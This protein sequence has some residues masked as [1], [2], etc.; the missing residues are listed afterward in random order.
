MKT[1]EEVDDGSLNILKAEG[2]N[3]NCL[4]NLKAIYGRRIRFSLCNIIDH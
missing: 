2:S 4:K 3:V 1:N